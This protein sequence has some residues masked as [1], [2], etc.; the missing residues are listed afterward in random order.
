M[1]TE[2]TSTIPANATDTAPVYTQADLYEMGFP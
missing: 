2:Q 1:D